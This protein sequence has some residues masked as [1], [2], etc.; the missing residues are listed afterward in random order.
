MKAIRLFLLALILPL[1]VQ[2]QV[3][4]PQSVQDF[5]SLPPSTYVQAR[6]LAASTAETIIPP[7]W[8]KFVLFA[9]TDN[10]YVNYTTTASVPGDTTDGSASEL[11]PS[12]RRLIRNGSAISSLSV[13]SAGTPVCTASFYQ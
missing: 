2:A 12:M 5:F 13:I 9:C 11:N 8:A 3:T 1:T 7:S 10:F 4:L 6:A